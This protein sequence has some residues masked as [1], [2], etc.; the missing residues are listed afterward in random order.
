MTSLTLHTEC[1]GTPVELLNLLKEAAE[2]PHAGFRR[3]LRFTAAMTPRSVSDDA[4]VDHWRALVPA[5]NLS[6]ADFECI[7]EGNIDTEPSAARLREAAGWLN[8]DVP[9]EVVARPL[10]LDPAYVTRLAGWLGI[11]ESRFGT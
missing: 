4:L 10:G 6:G 2:D 8:E 1:D 9:P 7:L 5:P 3:T 11:V